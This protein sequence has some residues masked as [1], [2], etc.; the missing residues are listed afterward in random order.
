MRYIHSCGIVHRD[1]KPSNILI[2]D[3][4]RAL[5]GDFGSSRFVYDDGTLTPVESPQPAAT[6]HYA[7]PE[8]LEDSTD[9]TLK[10]DV[11]AF[12]LILFEILVGRPVFARSLFP[13]E[14]IRKLK[15]RDLPA[16]PIDQCGSLMSNLIGRCWLKD[17]SSRPSFE[18]ILCEF[19][20]NHFRIVPGADSARITDVVLGILKWESEA[21]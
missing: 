19:Q 21:V 13:M 5:I 2:R 15:A 18:A 20:M 11:F 14:V 8:M 12:G 9:H 4:W 17:P 3:Q 16:I 6:V 10:V 1:L 7:A